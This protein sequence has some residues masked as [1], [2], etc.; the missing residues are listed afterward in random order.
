MQPRDLLILK[1]NSSDKTNMAKNLISVLAVVVAMSSNVL[2]GITLSN[3]LGDDMVLQRAPASA[4]VWGFGT[5]GV[6]V[7]AAFQGQ[8]LKATVGAD[9]VFR[10]VLP[11]TPATSTPTTITFTASD[12]SKTALNNVLFGEV[13]LCGG[14]SNMQYTPRSMA[15]MNNM[16]AE[17]A[18]ADG[19]PNIRLFTVGQ[20]T[21]G[22]L[23]LS[24]LATIEQNW[25]K[26]SSAAVG[27]TAWNTFSAVCF[28]F[29]RNVY[30]GLNG[31]VPVGL[32]SNNWGGTPVQSW[33]SAASMKVC[34]ATGG[35]DLYNPMINPYT[36][37]PMKF[38]GA[39]W[40][41]G[42][43]NVGQASTYSCEFPSMIEGWRAALGVPSLW[44][45]FVQIAGYNYGP[46]Y[47]AGD[48]RQAELAAL[49]LKNIGLSTAIDTGDFKNIHPPDKQTPSKRL[50][51]GFLK[52]TFN[53]GDGVTFPLYAMSTASMAGATVS[54]TVSFAAGSTGTGLTT[55]APASAT[56][57][58]T[59][60]QPDSV[61]RNQCVTMIAAFGAVAAD[62]GYPQIYGMVGTTATV[63][64]ATAAISSDG[65]SLVLSAAAPAGFKVSASSYGRGSWPMTV[66]FNSFGQP[67]IPFYANVGSSELIMNFDSVSNVAVDAAVRPEQ[68]RV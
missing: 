50:S 49:T 61:P 8:T 13:F 3:T 32:V 35:T 1:L 30:E 23:P 19:F 7:E 56:A 60:G 2:G 62:C 39:T 45:G 10:F 24:Q 21:R 29:G 42:E 28:L 12:G 26:S 54:V 5:A 38:N 4:T 11:P 67:V 59:L 68:Y 36:I 65:H 58:S 63:L 22:G 37:G 64:N 9:G 14:Q 20:K 43:A 53:I 57:S 17:I 40:Y 33:S 66:F 55:T 48:L 31:D 41:Q 52:A 18:S 6:T 44:F 15:G 16:T 47:N 27:G 25:T 46:S 34:N 51:D